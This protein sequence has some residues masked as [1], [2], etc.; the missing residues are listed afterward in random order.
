MRLQMETKVEF[1]DSSFPRKLQFD[2]LNIGDAAP[3][4]ELPDADM[5]VVTLSQFKGRRKVVLYFYP[6]DDTPG[7][8]L[9]AVEFSELEEQ[10]DK[11]NTVV[12]GVS[13]DDCVSHGHF[14]DKHGLTVRLLADTDGEVCTRYGVLQEREV[15][16]KQKRMAGRS[17]FIIDAAGI[18]RH[19]LA[20]VTPKHHAQDML[21][22]VKELS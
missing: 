16:G 13:T 9:Q 17:T 7:C 3:N 1:T 12:L 20:G 15:D 14:R 10:F 11:C 22:L 8:T 4:F 21:N 6:K 18:V 5:D 2:M 19:C